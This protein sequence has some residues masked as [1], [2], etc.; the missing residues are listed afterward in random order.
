[1]PPNVIFGLLGVKNQTALDL[2]MYQ[3]QQSEIGA[4][5]ILNGHASQCVIFLY[6]LFNSNKYAQK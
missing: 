2:M 6:N 1:M 4:Y 3:T 5:N